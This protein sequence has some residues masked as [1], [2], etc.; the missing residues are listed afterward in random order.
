MYTV[1]AVPLIIIPTTSKRSAG[2]C[3][4]NAEARSALYV[5][6]AV[7]LKPPATRVVKAELWRVQRYTATSCSGATSIN[8][9]KKPT[10]LP[11]RQARNW[12]AA[13]RPSA[14][15]STSKSVRGSDRTE[16]HDKSAAANAPS[17]STSTSSKPSRPRSKRTASGGV[18]PSAASGFPASVSRGGEQGGRALRLSRTPSWPRSASSKASETAEGLFLRSTKRLLFSASWSSKTDLR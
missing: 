2:S 3:A 4:S 18:S 12:N 7:D 10:K 6:M 14:S 9:I 17:S 11:A 15:K 8:A 13:E 1:D 16:F 5:E